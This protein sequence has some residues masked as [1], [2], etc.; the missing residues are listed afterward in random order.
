MSNQLTAPV[1]RF[2]DAY[3]VQRDTAAALP[4]FGD[5]A[6][7]HWQSQTM[8]AQSY[9]QVGKMFLA[10]FPDLSYQIDE[11]LIAGDRVVTRGTWSGTNTGS[12]MGQPATGKPFST[13]SVVIDRVVAGKI[14]E[15]WEVGDVLG[16]MQQLGLAPAS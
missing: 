11:Q 15:R 5:G 9:E 6:V 1:S 2:Y 3:T 10:G 13:V 14:V 7:I 16:M 8:D 4:V 12:L